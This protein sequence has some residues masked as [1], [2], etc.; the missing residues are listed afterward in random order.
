MYRKINRDIQCGVFW[1]IINTYLFLVNFFCLMFE[2]AK[3]LMGQLKKQVN[4]VS[5]LL[6]R[7]QFETMAPEDLCCLLLDITWEKS[8]FTSQLFTSPYVVVVV[9]LHFQSF[10][11]PIFSLVLI[12]QQPPLRNLRN[13][14]R[15][16]LNNW[17]L[18]KGYCNNYALFK[19]RVDNYPV[20]CKGK[21]MPV[22]H[23]QQSMVWI[24]WP[25]N[26]P[27]KVT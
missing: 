10:K 8:L 6:Q 14:N 23:K 11:A 20:F 5:A 22:L 1:N 15:T 24:T 13:R 27:R 4:N 12:W 25:I 19:V 18:M 17:S 2:N 16:V 7:K 26:F 3:V 9:L 21:N